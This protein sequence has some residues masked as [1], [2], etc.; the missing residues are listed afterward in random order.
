M[1]QDYTYIDTSSQLPPT[2]SSSSD[3]PINQHPSNSI[4][5]AASSNLSMPP[6]QPIT[7]ASPD[8]HDSHQYSYVRSISESHP[9]LL[10]IP[11][12]P[13]TRHLSYENLS[14][15]DDDTELLKSPITTSCLS[16]PSASR[17]SPI[18]HGFSDSES[19]S[20]TSELVQPSLLRH[21]P[22]ISR[23]FHSLPSPSQQFFSL[24]SASD[25]P[26]SSPPSFSPAIPQPLTMGMAG[27]LHFYTDLDTNSLFLLQNT[28]MGK[29]PGVLY[30]C[31]TGEVQIESESSE[32]TELAA[33]KFRNAYMVVMKQKVS[34]GVDVAAELME[35][36]VE[37]II[38]SQTSQCALLYDG[39]DSSI[40]VL[41]LSAR[42]VMQ[43]KVSLE[44]ALHKAVDPGKTTATDR[45]RAASDASMQT[46]KTVQ[47]SARM[48]LTVRIGDL[49]LED[50]E[51]L[52]CP[53]SSN[54]ACK[55]GP[56]KLVNE[57]SYGSVA[58]QCKDF[59]TKHGL[60]GFGHS[61][62]TK[63]GGNLKCKYVIH[64]NSGVSS[65][66]D[67]Y[68]TLKR[69]VVQ[70]LKMATQKG[71]P[72]IAFSPLTSSGWA[73]A[74]IDVV[75]QTMISTLTEFASQKKRQKLRDI[76]IIVKDQNVFDSFIEH[77]HL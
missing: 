14:N 7:P 8:S 13:P 45:Q 72:S 70:A 63:G 17:R 43:A 56:V 48:N 64:A 28:D 9:G 73:E 1:V 29:I 5:T 6:H 32:K 68:Q 37:K 65:S 30:K 50:A 23:N 61:V 62:V 76:R 22:V 44:A 49:G 16:L 74:D 47:L 38:A 12:A 71:A 55:D 18:I 69:L 34:V 20:D 19:D 39:I 31:E 41:G 58:R 51:F 53:N 77:A 75:A 36:T 3:P 10:S 21:S 40:Q 42:E 15:V 35:S 25:L 57:L 67:V 11:S 60:L 27:K 33:E 66:G 59:I 24:P 52:V 26:I 54:L 4:P 46:S 2:S